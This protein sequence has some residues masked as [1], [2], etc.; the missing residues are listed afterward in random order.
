MSLAVRHPLVLWNSRSALGLGLWPALRGRQWRGKQG[1]GTVKTSAEA[2]GWAVRCATAPL[3]LLLVLPLAVSADIADDIYWESVESCEDLGEVESYLEQFPQGRHEREAAECIAWDAVKG[4]EAIEEV[5]RFVQEFPQG[6]YAQE[7]AECI[8]VARRQEE[9]QRQRR[10]RIERLLAE[11]RAHREAGRLTAGVGGSA[12]EC[13]RKV[14]DEDPGNEQALAG[15]AGI[16]EHYAARARAALESE[17]PAAVRRSLERLEAI[18]PEHPALEELGM[19]LEELERRLAAREALVAESDAALERG[20]HEAARTALREARALGLPEERYE[21]HAR[22]IDRRAQEALR[23]EVEALLARGE[24]EQARERLAAARKAGLS[25]K[26]LA[27][28]EE[29]VEEGLARAEAAREREALVAEARDLLGRGDFAGARERLEE[30]LQRGLDDEAHGA[31]TKA[32]DEAETAANE[33]AAREALVAE[34][35][36]ALE[37]GEYEAA[38]EALREARASGLPEA[39]YEERLWR[40]DRREAEAHAR[41]VADLLAE[42]REHESGRRLGEAL[43]CFRR[44]LEWDEGNAEAA[45]GVERLEGLAAWVQA[46]ETHTVEGYYAFEQAHA[47][48]RFA[49]LARQ[50]LER[51]E[52]AYWAEVRAADAQEGYERYLEIYPEGRFV[53]LAKRRVSREE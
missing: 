15:I 37:R 23:T 47:G 13:Y 9:E 43:D 36:A 33:E 19:G 16:E 21:E 20:E 49:G 7:A 35:D 18:S 12:L 26:G 27:A 29:R 46:R 51:L 11:C 5:E 30:A 52:P 38:R 40:I 4:C 10:E 41:R 2:R 1:V 39:S 22:R 45:A 17:R 32:I 24:H 31:L 53:E 8:D 44:V 25:G 14:L 34:S 3:A 50:R 6:R 48:S 28:L 42:C